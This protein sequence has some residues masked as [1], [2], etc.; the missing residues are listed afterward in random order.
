[1]VQ[2][3][4]LNEKEQRR[5]MSGSRERAVRSKMKA[6]AGKTGSVQHEAGSSRHIESRF[7]GG[8]KV[9]PFE[10]ADE[11]RSVGGWT[12]L[13]AG[14]GVGQGAD[15]PQRSSTAMGLPRQRSRKHA[16]PPTLLH[17]Q[18]VS[19][20]PRLSLEGL[21][22][23]GSRQDRRRGDAVDDEY[24]EEQARA[25][26][27]PE[28]A[29][30]PMS[31]RSS[32]TRS[33]RSIMQRQAPGTLIQSSTLIHNAVKRHAIPSLG[34]Q[35]SSSGLGLASWRAIEAPGSLTGRIPQK[36]LGA[37]AVAAGDEARES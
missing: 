6:L 26:E 3:Q 11:R 21:N 5:L 1:M 12:S 9:S 17:A 36:R 23:D 32:V 15:L 18:S 8:M 14:P 7:K 13:T 20:I 10:G 33:I 24:A 2:R 27:R 30:A 37:G 19:S 34:L 31:A 25:S 22:R 16:G 28:F 35:R 29:K 4:L